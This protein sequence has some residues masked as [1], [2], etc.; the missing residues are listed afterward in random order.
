MQLLLCSDGMPQV[1][2]PIEGL[3][4]NTIEGIVIDVESLRYR[5]VHADVQALRAETGADGL[6][7]VVGKHDRVDDRIMMGDRLVVMVFDGAAQILRQF[8]EARQHAAD[9]RVIA[10]DEL[11]LRVHPGQM[12]SFAE[13]DHVRGPDLHGSDQHE[14]ADVV[15]Q[16]C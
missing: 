16:R 7:D 9:F 2:E 14:L 11:S 12:L 6:G 3:Q 5:R 1:L 4:A 10:A 8:L 15:H 13:R